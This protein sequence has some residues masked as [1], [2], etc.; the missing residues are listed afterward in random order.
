MLLWQIYSYRAGE[1]ITTAFAPGS[2]RARPARKLDWDHLVMV[3]GIVV[4]AVGSKLVIAHPTGHTPWSWVLVIVGGPA[5]FLIG[6]IHFGWVV[7]AHLSLPRVIGLGVLAVLAPVMSLFPPILVGAAV[8]AVL[9][10]MISP[11]LPDLW[12]PAHF[13]PPNTRRKKAVAPGPA[14][15][16]PGASES[17]AADSQPPTSGEA[18]A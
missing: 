18:N 13:M 6:R 11:D 2:A 9:V 12:R 1:R 16:K 4:A 8:A 7:F 15:A 5:L 10:G 3:G 17:G 14:E